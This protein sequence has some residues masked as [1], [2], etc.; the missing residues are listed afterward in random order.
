MIIKNHDIRLN[1][2]GYWPRN[3]RLA[4]LCLIAVFSF[5][6]AG[7]S[8]VLPAFQH[9][10][11]LAQKENTLKNM[12]VKEQPIVA[13]IKAYQNQAILIERNLKILTEQIPS[14]AKLAELIHTIS[15]EGHTQGIFFVSIEP[16]PEFK[17]KGYQRIPL[18]LTVI[19]NYAAIALFM[20]KL[21]NLP[22]LVTLGDF[23]LQK[24]EDKHFDKS[25]LQLSFTLESY[26]ASI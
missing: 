18:Q 26:Y 12:L 22:R 4:V 25:A 13:N 23:S 7:L 1:N 21:F 5:L 8:L 10:T 16:V 11:Q 15:S 14:H 19:G 9:F 17:E 3:I 24:S 20:Q 6:I 2:I